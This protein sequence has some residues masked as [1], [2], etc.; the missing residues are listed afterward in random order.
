[1]ESKFKAL[2]LVSSISLGAVKNAIVR[3]ILPI[4]IPKNPIN[5]I[6]NTVPQKIN[7]PDISKR[8]WFK[9]IDNSVKAFLRLITAKIANP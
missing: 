5:I 7:F 4:N 3:S 8:F 2:L 1:V 6:D 9:V